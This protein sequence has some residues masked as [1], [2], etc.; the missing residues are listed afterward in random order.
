[1][2]DGGAGEYYSLSGAVRGSTFAGHA[3]FPARNIPSAGAASARIGAVR[4]VTAPRPR[5]RGNG[6]PLGTEF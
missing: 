1:L 3:D 4:T 6:F 5:E 2:I